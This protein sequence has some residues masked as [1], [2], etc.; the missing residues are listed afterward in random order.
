MLSAKQDG[1]KYHF[2]RIW[3]DS[4]WDW[5]PF[6]LTIGEQKYFTIEMQSKLFYGRNNQRI[7]SLY[8]S[9][10]IFVEIDW[11]SNNSRSIC[12]YM[13]WTEDIV[14]LIDSYKISPPFS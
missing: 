1:I 11:K 12:L 2:L 5:T 4:T 8:N 3:C 6:S 14:R 9:F 13:T 7:I 10:E